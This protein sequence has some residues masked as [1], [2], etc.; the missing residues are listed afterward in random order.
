MTKHKNLLSGYRHVFLPLTDVYDAGGRQVLQDLGEES[1]GKNAIVITLG[2]TYRIEEL[3]Q[4]NP[5]GGARDALKF[6]TELRK[7]GGEQVGEGVRVYSVSEGL[8][9]ISLG[10]GFE[11]DEIS[12]ESLDRRVSELIF[13][14]NEN[15]RLRFLTP[16][17]AELWRLE[18][19]GLH[20]EKPRCLFATPEII[21]SW[22]VEGNSDLEAALY[23]KGRVVGINEAREMLGQDV[24]FHN[25]FIHFSNGTYARITGDLVRRGREVIDY[26]NQRVVLLDGKADKD[27][28]ITAAGRNQH[29]VL[30]I[31][32]KDHEQFLAFQYAL[33][34]PDISLVFL[35]GG[36]G[37]GKTVLSYVAAMDQIMK[38]QG[39]KAEGR[40]KRQAGREPFYDRSILIKSIDLMGGASRD[41]GFLPGT[42]MDKLGPHLK[43]YSDAHR[44]SNLRSIPFGEMFAEP[45]PTKRDQRRLI[46]GGYL[47]AHTSPVELVHT[48]HARGRSFHDAYMILDEA[49][50]LT[51]YEAKTLIQRLAEGCKVVLLGDPFGQ[52]DNV[53]CSPD[54]NGLVH[55][56]RHFR[57][58]AYSAM[59]TLPHSYRSPMA[60]DAET[61]AAHQPRSR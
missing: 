53:N 48:A 25:Q 12:L 58:K 5:L 43:P 1:G 29:G 59:I 23:T 7:I 61:W 34:D 60:R 30:G 50:N 21:N 32:P 10:S 17:E 55:A 14:I 47:P 15:N 19:R 33:L 49:Q 13:D 52:I 6:L 56:I 24:L 40:G 27:H 11:E 16:N 41:V 4:K 26:K 51:P 35:C 39:G 42:L 31:N 57:G 45:D 28:T 37:C 8:D 20:G 2:S 18:N 46:D 36:A 3:T 22:V 44:L 38:F 9:V 54:Y